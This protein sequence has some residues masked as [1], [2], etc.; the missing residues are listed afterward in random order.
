MKTIFSVTCATV[1]TATALLAQQAID[2]S[3]VP[4]RPEARAALK[5]K[6]KFARSPFPNSAN[7]GRKFNPVGGLVTPLSTEPSQKV[8]VIFIDFTTPPPGGP[9]ARLSL[10]YFDDM[11]FGDVYD[12]P[13]YAN[14]LGHPIDRTLKNYYAFNSYGQV[15]VATVN[16]NMPSA[17]GWT[18]ST[19]PYDYYCKADGLHDNGFGPFPQNAAGLVFEA[20]QLVDSK[21]DFS[22]YAVNGVVPNIFVVHSGTGAEWS[23]DPSILWSHSWS[24]SEASGSALTAD[25]VRVDNYAMMPEVGGDLTG[26]AGDASGPFPPTVGVYAHEFAHVLG[27]PDQ[28]DYGYESEGTGIF[29]LMAAG[30]W[31]AYPAGD[32]FAGNS[33]SN[34]DAW[35]KYRLGFVVPTDVTSPTQV[36]LGAAGLVPQIYKMVVPYS[37]GKEYYLFENRQPVNFDQGLRGGAM[38]GLVIYHIDD[39]VLS[40]NYWR[41]NEAENWKE[42]RSLGWQKAWT[43][44]SHYGISVIQADDQ[45][46]LEHGLGVGSFPDMFPG[47]YGK[48]EFSSTTA[49]NTSSY[50]FWPGA[51]PP[52]GWSH[53][54]VSNIA[55]SS[56]AEPSDRV[57]TADM[58]YEP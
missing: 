3:L 7:R 56:I 8:L 5:A 19:H 17:L 30:S 52:F 31:N 27:L 35:S 33:P 43:G 26:Y 6:G 28:Y 21:V 50:Y 25:G 13:E 15:D 37:G 45:W 54:K 14:T 12:P 58:G 55:E 49:P 29:S 48:T 4:L 38:H 53:V 18:H 57:I 1:L 42:V 41:P 11:L 47:Y 40:R 24:L 22:Q 36:T 20:V 10:N 16:I 34:L 32:L 51:A 9:A 23:S 44:E 46:H 2:F 39:T